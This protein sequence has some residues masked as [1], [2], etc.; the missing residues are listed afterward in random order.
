LHEEIVG[1][2]GEAFERAWPLR[3]CDVDPSAAI[4]AEAARERDDLQVMVSMLGGNADRVIDAFNG[5][6]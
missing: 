5:F 2:L 6:G 1:F 3:I 4:A